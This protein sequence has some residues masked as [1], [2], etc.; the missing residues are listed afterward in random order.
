MRREASAS[1]WGEQCVQAQFLKVVRMFVLITENASEKVRC[2][3]PATRYVL[4]QSYPS[5]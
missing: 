1:L 2:H 4:N 5:A 3:F